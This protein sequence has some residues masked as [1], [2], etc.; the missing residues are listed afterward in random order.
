MRLIGP[1]LFRVFLI[2]IGLYVAI[3]ALTQC[4]APALITSKKTIEERF[5]GK[6]YQPEFFTYQVQGSTMH[7]ARIG[8]ITKPMVIIVHG[9]PGGWGGEYLMYFKDSS[10]I[11]D[12]CL[13]SVD[14]AGYGISNGGIAE[15]S[16]EQQAAMLI[17]ILSTTKA[18]Q[19][20]ILV[21]HSLGGPI[22][23]R[24]AMDYPDAMKSLIFLAP[25]IDPKMEKNEWWRYILKSGIVRAILPQMLVTSNL[26]LMP[27]EEELELMLPLWENIKVPC[28]IM[29]GKK[30]MLVPYGNVPFYKKMLVNAPQK[31]VVSFEKENHFIPW[32]K[33]DSVKMKIME[34]L[35]Y[36]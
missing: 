14:R 30:D 7:Y 25:S 12:I 9:S 26:E 36:Q 24:M 32:T 35:E 6:K 34:H 15:P 3:G 20:P 29:H 4:A 5:K 8:D 11:D 10:L 21:G 18:K 23:A 17:P 22:I 19:K 16:L 33:Y 1:I 28:T 27:L 13:V 31:E 2:I